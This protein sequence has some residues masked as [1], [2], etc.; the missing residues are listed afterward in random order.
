MGWEPRR[1]S[2]VPEQQPRRETETRAS[3]PVA[4]EVQVEGA[5]LAA[6]CQSHALCLSCRCEWSKYE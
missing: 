4:V 2:G 1:G 5:A 3:Q 6:V